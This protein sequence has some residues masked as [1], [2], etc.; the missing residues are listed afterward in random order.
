LAGKEV[1]STRKRL[2]RVVAE[3]EEDEEE[4]LEVPQKEAQPQVGRQAGGPLTPPGL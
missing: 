1:A 4:E 3:E 2:R